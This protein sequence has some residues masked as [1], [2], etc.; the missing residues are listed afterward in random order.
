M[1]VTRRFVGVSPHAP[2]QPG[3]R[4]RWG[5]AGQAVHVDFLG[6]PRDHLPHFLRGS[7]NQNVMRNAAANDFS[8]LII[9]LDFEFRRPPRRLGKFCLELF[10]PIVHDRSFEKTCFTRTPQLPH[11]L[12]KRRF[13][14]LTFF[15]EPKTNKRRNSLVA[16]L[17]NLPG[18]DTFIALTEIA[19][20]HPDPSYRPWFELHAKTQAEVDADISPWSPE[21]F[22]EFANRLERTPANHRELAELARM[23]LLDLKDDL[24]NGDSSIA[25]ILRNVDLETS[26]RKFIGRELRAQAFGRYNIPQEEELADA[27][28]PDLRFHGVGFDGPV[29]C[30][31]KL[32][33]KWTGAS[34]FERL[35]NQLC[36]DYL[37]DKA[38]T[39]GIFLLVHRGKK[40]AWTVPGTGKRVDFLGLVELLRKCWQDI[41]LNYPGIDQIEVIGIDLTQRSR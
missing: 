21:Q 16:L 10:Q 15:T 4:A 40:K 1:E 39:H 13:P 5:C 27:K 22:C 32:A 26:M 20:A 11:L 7:L 2:P 3:Q 33:D 19:K 37:R 8:L 12:K 25:E 6:H 9:Q 41:A 14:L 38:S 31:L 34:L 30:E 23:R 24:E 36:G 35:E 17:R 29:P 18:K 28:K